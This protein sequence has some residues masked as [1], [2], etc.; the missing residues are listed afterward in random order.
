MMVDDNLAM[1]KAHG[2][3]QFDLEEYDRPRHATP[4]VQI[5]GLQ[6]KASQVR[7]PTIKQNTNRTITWSMHID[8]QDVN[9]LRRSALH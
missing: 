4:F 8:L 2:A 9:L 5:N 7:W 6:C 1:E 3:I